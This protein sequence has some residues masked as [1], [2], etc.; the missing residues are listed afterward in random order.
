ML[1]VADGKGPGIIAT[2]IGVAFS[3][4][5]RSGM[6]LEAQNPGRVVLLAPKFIGQVPTPQICLQLQ[7]SRDCME[8]SIY[9]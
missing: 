2:R 9:Q 5:H 6:Q 1:L 8:F 7:S 3:F 4:R